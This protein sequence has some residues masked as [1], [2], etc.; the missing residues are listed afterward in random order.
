MMSSGEMLKKKIQIDPGT[1]C[2]TIEKFLKEKM[3][4]M[5]RKGIVIGLSG[6]VDSAVVACLSVRAV[7]PERVRCLFMPEKH[8][9]KQSG[10][11]ARLIAEQL[12]VDLKVR[13][14]TSKLNKFG[15]YRFVPG[16]LPIF[17]VRQA[18][19]SL[20]KAQGDASFE[21]GLGESDNKLIAK[22]NAF[23]RIKHRMRMM[24]LYYLAESKDLL[25]VGGANQSEYAIGYFVSHGCD[26][27]TDIMPIRHL[28]KTQ[29]LQ[30]A[31]YL[32]IPREIIEK[33]P[34]PDFIPGM[35]DEGIIGLSYRNL[36]LILLGLD[37]GYSTSEIV[38]EIG[39]EPTDVD[40]V[41]K[42]KKKSR[43]RREIP[44]I[45]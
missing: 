41:I 9:D 27:A 39:C 32:E 26:N 31:E 10:K 25:V 2:H 43:Y 29:I 13:N 21:N 40:Y 34:S 12:G 6:G 22:A 7:G 37:A 14:L 8:S 16:R 3:L 45:V 33:P 24:M 23:Y 5:E 1:V 38:S 18:L 17:F 44:Y 15:A 11:H 42:L 36:D 19:I 30:L 4:E 28:Y 20:N 35:T